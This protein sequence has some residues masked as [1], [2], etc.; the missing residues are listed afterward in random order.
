MKRRRNPRA[1]HTRQGDPFHACRA[2]TD[3]FETLQAAARC[4]FQ[5]SPAR[6]SM[7]AGRAASFWEIVPVAMTGDVASCEVGL[8][9]WAEDE[10]SLGADYELFSELMWAKVWDGEYVA[11]EPAEV[12]RVFRSLAIRLPTPQAACIFYADDLCRRLIAGE[13]SAE[14]ALAALAAIPTSFRTIHGTTADAYL[15][16]ALAGARALANNLNPQT[17]ELVTSPSQLAALARTE[18]ERIRAA[19]APRVIRSDD[20][21]DWPSALDQLTHRRQ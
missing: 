9:K 14:D 5:A 13:V 11:C 10:Y 8:V 19:L 21:A 17:Y 4:W 16:N 20:P 2:R 1:E 18:A 12:T 7:V 15:A 3:H 6:Q